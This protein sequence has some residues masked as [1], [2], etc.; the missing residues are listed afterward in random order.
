MIGLFSCVNA[1][2]ALQRLQVAEAGSTDLTGIWLLPR[3]DQHMGTE[4]SNL[5]QTKHTNKSFT[6]LFVWFIKSQ[7]ME[8]KIVHP[9][10]SK[11]RANNVHI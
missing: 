9:S 6:R 8:N 7:N 3:V 1:Q 2:V 5:K 10:S 4:M 11:F